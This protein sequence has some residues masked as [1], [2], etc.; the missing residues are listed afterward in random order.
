MQITKK[1]RQIMLAGLVVALA[2][3]V[4]ANWYFTGP[5]K[6][7]TIAESESNNNENVNNLGDAIYVDS[8]NVSDEYFASAKLSRDVSYDEAIATLMEIIECSE[9]DEQSIKTATYSMND[10]AQKKIQQTN[11]ENLVEAKTGNQCVAVITEDKVEVII[12][13]EVLSD[14]V[15]LQIKE[16]V[17]DNSE[18]SFEKVII[19]P[20][21]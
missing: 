16:I 4:F 19:I 21:K 10:M 9:V 17:M 13:K 5:Q 20:A 11:I 8:T 6:S 12:S 18:F 15:I 2:V 1:K 7:P 3:A 14:S